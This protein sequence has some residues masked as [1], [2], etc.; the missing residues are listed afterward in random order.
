MPFDRGERWDA[1]DL[2]ARRALLRKS[3]GIVRRSDWD[4][5]RRLGKD[6]SMEVTFGLIFDLTI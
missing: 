2:F 6:W 1:Q 3:S 5:L 4:D